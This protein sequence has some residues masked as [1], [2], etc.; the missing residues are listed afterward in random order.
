MANANHTPIGSRRGGVPSRRFRGGPSRGGRLLH[1]DR[2]Q[3]RGLGPFDSD[4]ESVQAGPSKKQ[5][6]ELSAENM[7]TNELSTIE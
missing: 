1:P 7:D 2:G 5:E 6:T 4:S 3:K